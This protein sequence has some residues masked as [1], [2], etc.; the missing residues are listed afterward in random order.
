MR[1]LKLFFREFWFEK[2]KTCVV[3]LNLLTLKFYSE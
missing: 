1:V 2:I 3:E